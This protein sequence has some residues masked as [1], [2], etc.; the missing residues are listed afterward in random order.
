MVLMRREQTAYRVTKRKSCE[1][2]AELHFRTAIAP[3][4]QNTS[5]K[6]QTWAPD[7]SSFDWSRRICLNLQNSTRN[8][9]SWT[10]PKTDF[11]LLSMPV[12]VLQIGIFFPA[13]S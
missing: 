10:K 11:L 3:W 1:S 13:T 9:A 8:Q 12:G 7:S 2:L 4:Q 5:N 6:L